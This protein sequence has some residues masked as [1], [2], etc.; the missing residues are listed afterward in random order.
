M[1]APTLRKAQITAKPCISSPK[2]YI[3]NA[4]HCISSRRAW[5]FP[6]LRWLPY[7]FTVS[8]SVSLLLWEKVAA[9][10]TDEAFYIC[11]VGTEILPFGKSSFGEANHHLHR[12]H[13]SPK[14]YVIAVKPQLKPYT[15]YLKTLP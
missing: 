4:K 15:L 5:I 6:P 1:T 9:E 12:I 11:A 13:R 3:I 8:V 10:P 7:V 2:A 14:V